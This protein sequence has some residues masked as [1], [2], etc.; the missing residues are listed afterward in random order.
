MACPFSTS[1]E[2]VGIVDDA[3]AD[4]VGQGGIGEVV[5]WRQ[6]TLVG[7][8]PAHPVKHPPRAGAPAWTVA[9]APRPRRGH[10]PS[11][12]TA[13]EKTDPV[14]LPRLL[15]FDGERRGKE[16]A[17]HGTEECSPLHYSIT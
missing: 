17:G 13:R 7:V 16:A 9:H 2:S 5:G 12:R 10:G 1:R 3:V 6:L 15:R 11:R 4:C 14:N 8:R